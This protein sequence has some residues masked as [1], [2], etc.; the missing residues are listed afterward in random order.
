MNRFFIPLRL[1]NVLFTL[2]FGMASV[3]ASAQEIKVDINRS[4]R[5]YTEGTDPAYTPWSTEYVWLSGDA[6]SATFEGITITFSRVGANGTALKSSYWKNGVV[7]LGVKLISDGIKVDNEDSGPA[8]TEMRISGLT[9]GRHT[10][11]TYHCDW[12]NHAAYTISPLTIDVDGV[13]AVTNLPV[14]VRVMTAAEAASAYLELDA[15][16]GQDVV[17]L[18]AADT[19]VGADKENVWMFRSRHLAF[20]GAE[21]YERFARGGRGGVVVKV[22]N[23]NDSGPGSFRDAIEGDYGP[24]TVIFDVAGLIDLSDDIRLTVL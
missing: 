7:D 11:L 13:R 1:A 24:R 21:G 18:F 15:V 2:F 23:L 16:E 4:G 17:V 9:P 5:K 10:L 20:P 8:Q 14:P 19:T 12:G 3:T 22:T 6:T